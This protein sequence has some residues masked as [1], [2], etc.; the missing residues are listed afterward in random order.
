MSHVERIL[1]LWYNKDGY[2]KKRR[3]RLKGFDDGRKGCGGKVKLT[4]DEVRAMRL[5]GEWRWPTKLVGQLYNVH[6]KY[7]SVVMRG[8]SHAH[9]R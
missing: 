6:P 7:A 4:D 5:A 1:P 2:K 8:D 3:Y 9:V